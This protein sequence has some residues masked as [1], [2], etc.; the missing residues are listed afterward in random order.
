MLS[1]DDVR[2]YRPDEVQ[3]P[4]QGL[5]AVSVG[6][7]IVSCKIVMDYELRLSNYF[8]SQDPEKLYEPLL[9]LRILSER[10]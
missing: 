6:I 7:S 8:F 1:V 10:K 4:L 3:Y 5:Q 9:N 2:Q